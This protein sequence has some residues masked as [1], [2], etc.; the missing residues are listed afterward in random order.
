[1]ILLKQSEDYDP[2]DPTVTGSIMYEPDLLPDGR[3][4]DFVIDRGNDNLY[5]EVKTRERKGKRYLHIA[6]RLDCRRSKI[7]RKAYN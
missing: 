3:K 2:G 5:I 4:I 1:M 7:F 6:Y